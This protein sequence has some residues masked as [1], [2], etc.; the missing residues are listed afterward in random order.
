MDTAIPVIAVFSALIM[1]LAYAFRLPA[2]RVREHLTE[3]WSETGDEV[4]PE[5]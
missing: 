5:I 4:L 2:D 3:A 1:W